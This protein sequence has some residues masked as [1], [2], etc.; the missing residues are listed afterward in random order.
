MGPTPSRCALRGQPSAVQFCSRQNCR[1]PE[2]SVH[3][4]LSARYAKRTFRGAPLLR[5]VR[6]DCWAHPWAQPLRA[7]RCGVSLR[8]SNFV[9][10]KIVEPRR[11]LSTPLSPPDT[12]NAPFGAL[13]C[14]VRSAGIVGPIHGP[15]PF[16]LRAAGPA[17]GCPILFQTKLSNPRGFVHTSLSARYA[18]RPERGVLRIWRRER[19]SNPR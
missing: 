11:V 7:A 5:E 4:S 18:K 9:P 6:G 15:N 17:F 8:L 13:H 3:T 10:D 2:G 1:T 19:D 16:A 14:Y 12:Q